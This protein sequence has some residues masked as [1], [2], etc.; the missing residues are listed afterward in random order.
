[1][2]AKQGY[3]WILTIPE[4]HWSVP[5]SLDATGNIDWIKGQLE[6][7]ESNFRHWQLVVHFKRKVALRTCK[8]AFCPEAHCEITRSSAANEYVWKEET[9]V[10][11]T[12]FEIGKLPIKRNCAK[13]WQAVWDLATEGKLLEIPADIRVLH[14]RTLRAISADYSLPLGMERTVHVFWGE[15]GTGKS[16]RA[17][18]EAGPLAYPKD[19]SSKF[20]C[21]YSGQ[22]SVVIDE[23]RGRIGIDHLLRWLDRYPVNVEIKGSSVPLCASNI[24][25]TSNL[26]PERWYPELDQLTLDALLRRLKITRFRKLQ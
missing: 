18:E 2:P 6:H 4:S 19:P 12:Q 20:W 13:D 24:W 11:G 7:S 25:I 15:T 21:G 5:E 22:T 3:Y 16:R 23:F 9:R 14:Y 26:S 8:A 17:W 1:M 10:D